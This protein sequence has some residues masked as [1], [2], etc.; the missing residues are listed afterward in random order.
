MAYVGFLPAVHILFI[1]AFLRTSAEVFALP[2]CSCLAHIIK[3][4]AE[5][6]ALPACMLPHGHLMNRY[7]ETGIS[8]TCLSEASSAEMPGAFQNGDEFSAECEHASGNRKLLVILGRQAA[9]SNTSRHVKTTPNTQC[10]PPGTQTRPHP[11]FQTDTPCIRMRLYASQIRAS[12]LKS[13]CC[14]PS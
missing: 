8:R 4:L 1:A 9:R 6:F 11:A 10:T 2:A 3:V 14:P 5:V 7:S 13:H 12:R